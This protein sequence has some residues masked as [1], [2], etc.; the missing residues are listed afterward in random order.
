MS[1][2]Y[3]RII[4]CVVVL[5]FYRKRGNAGRVPRFRIGEPVL[6]VPRFYHVHR[7]SVTKKI[8][9]ASGHLEVKNCTKIYL[10]SP[11]PLASGRGLTAP[12]QE[13]HPLRPSD[14]CSPFALP[15]KKIL[16]APMAW[17]I[18]NHFFTITHFSS[19]L[20]DLLSHPEAGYLA[21]N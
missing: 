8:A 21:P 9:A 2:Y 19:F 16:R 11:D 13:P 1:V 6:I 15:W 7:R 5:V 14:L 20:C 10:R 17:H 12:P 3:K 18:F 4:L